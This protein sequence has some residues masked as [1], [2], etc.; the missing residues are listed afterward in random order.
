MAPKHK[1][2]AKQSKET[3]E[4]LLKKKSYK[5]LNAWRMDDPKYY[6]WAKT[7][8]DYWATLLSKYFK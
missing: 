3:V 8:L 7:D 1:K 2:K 4:A 5:N 6:G